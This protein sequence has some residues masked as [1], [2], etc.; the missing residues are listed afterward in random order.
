MSPYIVVGMIVKNEEQLIRYS[1]GSVYNFADKIVIVDHE[2]TDKTVS[3]LKEID[4]DNKITIINRKWDN[5]YSNARNTYLDYIRKNIYPKY[6]TNTYYFRV[7]ADEV[8]F[9][10]RLESLKEVIEENPDKEGF[11]FNFYTFTKDYGH[12]D[13]I[14]PTE[15]RAN[16]F[17]FSPDIYYA[18][19][20]H[21]MPVHK[22]NG[23][24]FYSSPFE[25][26]RLGIYQVGSFGYLHFAWCDVQRCYPKAKN[27]TEH[28]VKQGTETVER[29]RTI[30]ASE[31][32]WWWD[33]KSNL[34]YTGK[35]PAVF[36]KYGYL[37]GQVPNNDSV[38]QST[39][40]SAYTIIKN[41]IKFD[42][43][44]VEAINSI[45]PAVDEVIVNCGDSEDAT[46]ELIHKAFDGIGKVKIHHRVWEGRD[47]G[48]AFLRNQ[49]NWAK[50]QCKNSIC[51]YLQSD[52]IYHEDDLAGLL[53]AA[54]KLEESPSLVA[55]V[56][57][58]NHFDGIPTHIN[59]DSYPAE[60]RLIKRNLLDSIGDAQSM[61]LKIAEMNN[62]MAF[63][64]F[65]L[66]TNVVVYHYGWLRD[67]DK[68]LAKLRD[69]DKY[70]H[71]DKEWLDMHKNDDSK[72]S[73]GKYNYGNKAN[74]FNGTHPSVMY[75][76][77]TRYENIN[78]LEHLSK[79]KESK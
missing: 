33:K 34:S 43:P 17:R 51:L 36:E 65:L 30:A 3:L 4:V 1:V 23:V 78:N 71:D 74:N 42:Y 52:E 28:Y 70:Y 46:D 73:N 27:Y 32:S 66:D 77:I 59:T 50:E 24:P 25:D 10:D 38:N 55:A 7:D 76:R 41:A 13:E 20:I 16:L 31:T 12:L 72:H 48:T 22:N 67:A 39:K 68:M 9:E 8:Y 57:K 64:Q 45:L 58:W 35:Y 40:I 15:S 79:F 56:F 62:V 11:R 21:E 54:K 49:S 53:D 75:P 61:G 29:L 18:N 19:G 5:N 47:K 69:F 26:S 60:V 6:K 44:I 2:S 63:P 37:N 14:S